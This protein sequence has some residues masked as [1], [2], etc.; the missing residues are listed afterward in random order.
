M[1]GIMISVL[2]Q[3]ISFNTENNSQQLQLSPFYKGEN[4]GLERWSNSASVTQGW[5]GRIWKCLWLWTSRICTL[6]CLW[7]TTW[8][9]PG[10]VS[11]LNV[12][13]IISWYSLVLGWSG[14]LWRRSRVHLECWEK[15]LFFISS[16]IMAGNI[17]EADGLGHF[18]TVWLCDH[19]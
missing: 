19:F 7:I 5:N 9:T 3:M 12:L 16:I 6:F 1:L 15:I 10:M 17:V 11:N 8:N 4:C 2:T 14:L 18:L 13:A